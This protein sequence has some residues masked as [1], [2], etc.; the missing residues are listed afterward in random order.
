MSTTTICGK[1]TP[2]FVVHHHH[3][4]HHHHTHLP[5][6]GEGRGVVEAPQVVLEPAG[7]ELQLVQGVLLGSGGVTGVV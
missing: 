4:R 6:P 7:V 5:I 3:H 2:P 1:L